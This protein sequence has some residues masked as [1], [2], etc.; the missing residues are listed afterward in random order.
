MRVASR[1]RRLPRGVRAAPA[2]A[3]HRPQAFGEVRAVAR[4]AGHRQVIESGLRHIPVR[5]NNAGEFRLSLLY[6]PL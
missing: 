2:R 3:R 1:V 6:L 5:Y 4:L